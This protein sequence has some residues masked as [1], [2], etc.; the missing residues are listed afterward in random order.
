MLIFIWNIRWEG[1]LFKYIKKRF[2]K[3]PSTRK[4]ND[5]AV[6]SVNRNNNLKSKLLA[7]KFKHH[8]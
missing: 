7:V 3:N 8:V 1:S 4:E 5:Y 2:F 6:K